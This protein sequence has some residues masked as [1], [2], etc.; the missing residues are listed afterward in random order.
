MIYDTNLLINHIRKNM[1][2]PTQ[3]VIPIVIVGEL[4]AFA[5]KADWGYQK[6]IRLRQI[7]DTYPIVAIDRELTRIYAQVD[8]YSQGKLMAYPGPEKFTARNMGKNDL[9]I[10]ATALY[11]DI[12]LHTHDK[13]FNHL[14]NFGLKLIYIG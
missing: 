7:I 2:L 10:A 14:S 5:L 3:L 9:W 1:L 13:D 4:E 12:E 6:I 8:A 11:L